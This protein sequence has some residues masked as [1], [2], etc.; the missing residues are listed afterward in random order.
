V[1]LSP[2]L[3]VIRQVGGLAVRSQPPSHTLGHAFSS[4]TQ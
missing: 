1:T 2:P 3:P 4:I